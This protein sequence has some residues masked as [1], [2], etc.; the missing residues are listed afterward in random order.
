MKTTTNAKELM[1]ARRRARVRA[2]VSGT[3]ERPRLS[4]F[5]SNRYLSAQLINDAAGTTLASAHGKSFKGTQSAQAVAVGKA[6]AEK[7]KALGIGA[8]VF[9]RGGYRYVGHVKELAD[10]AREGGLSF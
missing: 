8:I 3:A 4:V 9:D 10:A 2:R 1:R 5:K 6:I 7:S